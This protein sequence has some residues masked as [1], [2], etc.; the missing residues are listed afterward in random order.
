M[1]NVTHTLVGLMLARVAAPR[2]KRPAAQGMMVIAANIPD[3]DVVTLFG[4]GMTYLQHH[5]EYTHALVFAPLLAMI[6]PLLFRLVA[7]QRLSLFTYVL[8]LVGVLSH[9]LLDWTN[10]YGVRLFLPFSARWLR[11]DIT[12]I[13]DPWILLVL[14]L[15]V[16]APALAKLVS[17][18]IGARSGEG[19]RRG[20]AW[21]ALGALL[22]YEGGRYI[23][24]ERAL[25]VLD[26]YIYN[27]DRARRITALPHRFNPLVWR[28]VVEGRNRDFTFL[29]VNLAERFDSGSGRTEYSAAQ[30]SPAIQAARRTPPF[31]VLEGFSQ[32]PFWQMTPAEDGVVVQLIDLRFGTPRSPG[33]ASATAVVDQNGQVRSARLGFGR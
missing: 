23:A 3:I 27:G 1:D 2:G 20:W 32:L 5:R 15:A 8:S 33:F 10:V 28:A 4:G 7:R 9:P 18:E 13:V 19:T 24:H 29:T 21:F 16:A 22:C 25:G 31:Q 6:P 12:D 26:S 14:I 30:D 11:L 17:S